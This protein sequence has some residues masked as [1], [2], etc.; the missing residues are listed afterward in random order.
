MGYALMW[1]ESLAAAVTFMAL[2]TAVTAR[3]QRRYGQGV[4]PVVIAV[5]LVAVAAAATAALCFLHSRL[6]AHPISNP[7]SIAAIAWTLFLAVGSVVV[8]VRGLRGS[9]P[10]ARAWSRAR[11]AVATVGLVAVTA[12]TL[13]NMD[14]AV[15]LQFTAVRA[16]A[17]AKLLAQIPPR[18]PDSTNAAV[19]YQEAFDYLAPPEPV[20]P[21][22]RDKAPGAWKAYDRE[23]F[24]PKDKDLREFLNTQQRGLAL[25]RKAAAIPGCSFDHDY[26]LGISMPLPELKWL[27]HAATLLAYDALVKAADGDVRGALDDVTAIYGVAGHV[28]DPL[29]ISVM[30]AIGI[31]KTATKVL[32]DVLSSITSAPDLG[33]LTLP[34]EAT[35]RRSV[36]RAMVTEDVIFGLTTFAALAE[37]D[38]GVI[39]AAATEG[40]DKW[41]P[42]SS[43]YRVFLMQDDLAA[44]RR[45]MQ[46]MQQLAAK[47]YYESH[48]DWKAHNDS[49]KGRRRGIVTALL[50]PATEMVV[51]AANEADAQR[52]LARTAL[53]LVAFKARTGA[54]PDKLDA[55]VPDLLTRVPLDPFSGRPLRMKRDGAGVVLYSVGRDMT[56][57]GG[58][59]TEPGKVGGDLVFR[60]K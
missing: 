59:P 56:D 12:I 29:L 35:Y 39:D 40:L 33:R 15:K 48:Q 16:E 60:L 1:L 26:S 51:L 54:Y 46:E 45:V 31:D 47:P 7:Q 21:L 43:I 18:L 30:V 20:P 55:L 32:E 58:R 14:M 19:V 13:A 28:S 17:G 34:V 41:I 27:P 42:A 8:L 38:Q 11:L 53:A 24:D 49:W 44:Y 50:A 52:L 22:W 10:A 37:G 9:E 57:D 23:A 4:I 25:I 5:V 3:W 6:D 36:R 2:V